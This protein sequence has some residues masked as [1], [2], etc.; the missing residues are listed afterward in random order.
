ML[1]SFLL[2]SHPHHASG[3]TKLGLRRDPTHTRIRFIGLRRQLCSA[4]DRLQI[5]CRPA[6]AVK[7]ASQPL[8]APAAMPAPTIARRGLSR[9]GDGEK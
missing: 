2:L 3:N 7:G 4:P 9:V 5:A 6:H 1:V 8:T